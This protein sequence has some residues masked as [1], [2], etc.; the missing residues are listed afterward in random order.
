MDVVIVGAGGHGK[1]VLEILRAA[2]LHRPV[3]FLDAD[4]SLAGTSVNGVPVLGAINFIPRLKQQK[5]KGAI[6]AIGDNRVRQAYA[7]TLA[8]HGLELVNAIHPSAVVSPT[9]KVGHDVVIA[10]GAIISA[11]V[12]LADSVICNTGCI[13]DHECEIGEAAH[14]AP[15]VAL[16]GRVRVGPMAF[17][18]IGAKVIPCLSVGE[19]S[20]VGAGAVVIRDVPPH[21]TVVGT[22][23]RAIRGRTSPQS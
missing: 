15:A 3:G 2:G 12:T 7:K 1:V 16:A 10:A 4:P 9:A 14:V 19:G 6:V 22:P 21:V 11:D 18:G 17:I 8:E 5:V 13:V 20:I 23:A